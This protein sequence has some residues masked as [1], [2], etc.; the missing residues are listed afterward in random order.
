MIHELIN[1]LPCIKDDKWDTKSS[2]VDE[3]ELV[4]VMCDFFKR[5][6]SEATIETLRKAQRNWLETKWNE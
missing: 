2:P 1:W 6:I 3:T 4:Q 5:N